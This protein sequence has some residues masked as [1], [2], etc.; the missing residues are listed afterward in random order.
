MQLA[1][2]E[3]LEAVA[4]AL[5]ERIAD[6]EDRQQHVPSAAQVRLCVYARGWVAVELGQ[7]CRERGSACRSAESGELS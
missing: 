6:A 2:A 7:T 4:P 5:L 3:R 1:E